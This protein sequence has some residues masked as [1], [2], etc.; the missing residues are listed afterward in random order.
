[1]STDIFNKLSYD[2][3]KAGITPRTR[4]SRNWFKQRVIDLKGPDINRRHILNA[5]SV[6]KRNTAI[7]GSMNMFYYDPKTKATLPYYDRFPCSIIVGPAPGGFYGINLHYLPLYPRFL[8]LE[9]LLDFANN[10]AF[11]ESTKI[12]VTYDLLKGSSKHRAFQP[13]FKHYLN[14]HV[15]SHFAMIPAKEWEIAAGLPTQ[16]FKGASASTVWSDSKKRIK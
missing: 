14:N 8:L 10:K 2:A 12:K 9:R 3:F 1:M 13:C 11:T 5:D 15:K 6:K 16:Q 7:I 4:A